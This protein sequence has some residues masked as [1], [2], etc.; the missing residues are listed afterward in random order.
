MYTNVNNSNMF[1]FAHIDITCDFVSKQ[2]RLFLT[3]CHNKRVMIIFSSIPLKH[4]IF[5]LFSA[6]LSWRHPVHSCV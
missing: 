4:A 5:I 2:S 6:D 3:R 1:K